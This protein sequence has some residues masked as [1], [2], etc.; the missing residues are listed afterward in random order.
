MASPT[1]WT[2]TGYSQG[3]VGPDFR[4]QVV[5]DIACRL[6]M[7]WNHGHQDP[8]HTT[9]IK[10]GVPFLEELKGPTFRFAPFN[11]LEPGETLIHTFQ[12]DDWQPKDIMTFAFKATLG[13]V[14]LISDGPVF[15]LEQLQ[16]APPL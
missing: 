5:T 9:L 2:I 6:F 3:F 15:H 7:I 1:R 13:G 16:N 12:P 8:H 11:Q 14:S 10:R 4:I